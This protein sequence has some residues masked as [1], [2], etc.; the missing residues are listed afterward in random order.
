MNF[1]TLEN[2]VSERGNPKKNLLK[3]LHDYIGIFEGKR[4]HPLD[5]EFTTQILSDFIRSRNSRA[6]AIEK[7][8]YIDFTK[9]IEKLLIYPIFGVDCIDGRVLPALIAGLVAKIGGFLRIPAGDPKEFVQQLGGG[10]FN[11]TVL[12]NGSNF[13]KRLDEAFDNR[14]DDVVEILD[15]HVKCAAREIEEKK[16]FKNSS[17]PDHGLFADV[18]R[19]KNIADAM[20][21]YVKTNNKRYETSK[22]VHP[23]QISFDPHNGY[24]YMGLE[25]E[26]AIKKAQQ[27]GNQFTDHVLTELSAEGKIISTYQI[28]HEQNVQEILRNKYFHVDWENK[29][30]D[31]A[32]KFWSNIKKI[33]DESP[34]FFNN[35]EGRVRSVFPDINDANEIKTRTILVLANLYSGFLLNTKGIYPYSEH[36]E[37]IIVVSEGGYSP[38]K[39]ASFG[40]H[41]LDEPN[42]PKA[43]KLAYDLIRNNRKENRANFGYQ[44]FEPNKNP[45]ETYNPKRRAAYNEAPVPIVVEEVVRFNKLKNEV[46][47]IGSQKNLEEER[48]WKEM[49]K[50]KDWSFLKEIN[51]I[52]MNDDEFKIYLRGRLSI[53]S[54]RDQRVYE[55]INNLRNRVASL[56]KD[57]TVYANEINPLEKA[58]SPARLVYE[59]KLAIL[60]IIGDKERGARVIIPFFASLKNIDFD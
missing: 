30:V 46:S 5:R 25:T 34:D 49:N 43:A 41:I 39:V 54:I 27:N 58:V 8:D 33:I 19:K 38:Y 17:I 15:S 23:I 18:M 55:E 21:S 14:G 37:E 2:R 28:A 50:I 45:F 6:D 11:R 42:I 57:K 47:K 60:S 52:D 4:L 48:F 29:Y 26:K 36:T 3:D 9:D 40:I 32:K 22:R 56:Y 31:T 1:T 53:Y 35:L 20:V 7:K 12:N 10:I 44:I 24:L 51:W 16:R 13:A 59:R